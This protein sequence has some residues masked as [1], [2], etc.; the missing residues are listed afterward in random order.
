MLRHY[1]GNDLTCLK[2]ADFASERVLLVYWYSTLV[3]NTREA[4][5]IYV[6]L[7]LQYR[8]LEK[9][10]TFIPFEYWTSLV[11]RSPVYPTAC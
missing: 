3:F 5:D 4:G 11:F 9:L 8:I 1:I 2:M 6:S 7:L 10:G